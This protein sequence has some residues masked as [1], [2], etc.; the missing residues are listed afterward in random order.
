MK[1]IQLTDIHTV[2]NEAERAQ[3]L[4]FVFSMQ[5][6]LNDALMGI[7][8]VR[9]LISPPYISIQ[10]SL[11]VHRISSSDQ[12]AIVAS[13]GLFDFFSNDEAVELAE[14]Y[15]L[16]N[17]FGDP[18]KFLVE[19]LIARAAEGFSTEELM[20]VPAGRRRKYHDDVTVI[21]IIL[22]MN[23]RTSKASTCI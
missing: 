3:L 17:P 1:A 4:V 15:I 11:N 19:Q 20:N 7:L 16:S 12:F 8:R 23:Q 10:P 5:K 18:A 21:V 6:I 9:D 2:D 14:S 13:D 22:G